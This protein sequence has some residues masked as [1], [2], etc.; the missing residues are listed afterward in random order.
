MMVDPNALPME[1][2]SETLEYSF[3]K[4]AL[5]AEALTH[6]SLSGLERPSLRGYG[7]HG[8]G[9]GHH[10]HT[11]PILAQPGRDYERLEFLGDRVLGLLIAEWLLERFPNDR[12]GALSKRLTALVRREALAVVARDM[13]LGDYLR[14]S[15]GEEA[16]GGRR[17]DTILADACEALIGAL[18]LDGGLKA[19]RA[20]VRREWTNRID[21]RDA[22]PVEPKTALQEWAQA[23]ALALPV[24]TLS[25]RDGPDHDPR[26]RVAVTV[27]GAGTAEGEGTSKRAAEKA[28]AST[29]LE[30]LTSEK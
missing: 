2:F 5:L 20:F 17:N 19:A 15:P 3:N 18:Y 1:A 23:R 6:S 28:A 21:V 12:E 8:R 4:P 25:G 22:P 7:S 26:F 14:M 10:G 30:R 29:L 27:V 13:G 24:Y 11:H 9:D 16:A